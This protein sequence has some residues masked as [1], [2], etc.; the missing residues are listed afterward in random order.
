M[1]GGFAFGGSGGRRCRQRRRCSRRRGSRAG[2]STRAGHGPDDRPLTVRC[3][4]PGRFL[5]LQ[6]NLMPPLF[7]PTF[8]YTPGPHT[9]KARVR[10]GTDLWDRCAGVLA[11][12]TLCFFMVAA[13]SAAAICRPCSRPTRSL[14]GKDE[15]ASC[16]I[17]EPQSTI[18]FF[19]FFTGA[20]RGGAPMVCR[21]LSNRFG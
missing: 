10:H 16:R 5:R 17:K 3:R 9:G 19:F 2:K 20:E 12:E 8:P 11:L 4:P 21:K 7:V 15:P 6:M 13:H 1:G 18:S 14:S